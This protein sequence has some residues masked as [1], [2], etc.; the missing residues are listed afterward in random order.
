MCPIVTIVGRA[1]RSFSRRHPCFGTGVS[2]CADMASLCG[3]LTGAFTFSSPV[4]VGLDRTRYVRFWPGAGQG[5]QFEFGRLVEGWDEVIVTC[6]MT[7]R[8]GGRGRNTEILSFGGDRI[9][10]AEVYLG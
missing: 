1:L 6:Q 4:D 7:R 10:S 2:D 3:L 8:E 9:T 5:Q